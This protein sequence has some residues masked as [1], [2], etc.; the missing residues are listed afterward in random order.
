MHAAVDAATDLAAAAGIDLA[1]HTGPA[2]VVIDGERLTQAVRH[3]LVDTVQASPG[4][5]TVVVAAA[6]RGAIA[7]IEIRGVEIGS[8]PEH[9]G[10]A[11]VVVERHGGA[12]SVHRVEGKGVTYVIELPAGPG[13][14]AEMAAAPPMNRALVEE[15]QIIPIVRDS[16]PAALGAASCHT[17]AGAAPAVRVPGR[18]SAATHQPAAS[19]GSGGMSH[20]MAPGMAGGV[21]NGVSRQ[22]NGIHGYGGW[23]P[24]GGRRP[25]GRGWSRSAP[26]RRRR[27]AANDAW[28]REE[29]PGSTTTRRRGRRAGSGRRRVRGREAGNGRGYPTRAT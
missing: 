20:G 17:G 12:I 24:A 28:F 10:F 19:A 13:A 18:R 2:E 3:L 15:T 4:G 25:P 27:S 26:R 23:I 11:R 21:S 14:E 22:S 1:V 7:R 5:S 8:E 16:G 6:R 29:S 9:L